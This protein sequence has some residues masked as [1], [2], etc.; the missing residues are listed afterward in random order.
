M[1]FFDIFASPM[2]SPLRMR[3]KVVSFFIF[4][5]AFKQ[6]KIK[7][8]RPNMTKIASRG[9]GPALKCR[10]KW[11]RRSLSLSLSLSLCLCEIYS[12][13]SD[14]RASDLCVCV[15]QWKKVPDELQ[16]RQATPAILQVSS[17]KHNARKVTTR[18]KGPFHYRALHKNSDKLFLTITACCNE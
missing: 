1:F 12:R 13:G 9:W 7:A 3:T 11:A 6:K 4:P 14:S 5:R 10:G 8:L 17:R 16:A 15:S 18:V 2:W